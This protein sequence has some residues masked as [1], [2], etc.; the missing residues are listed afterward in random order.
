MTGKM[1]I[2]H[3]S[4]LHIGKQL[5]LYDISEVQRNVLAQIVELAKKERPDV[6]VIAGDIYDKAAPSGEAFRL[7]DEFLNGLG[8]IEPM[9]PVLIIAGNHDNHLRLH[10]ASSFLEKHQIYISSSLPKT[11]DEHLKK[12]VLEDE[13]GT[14]NFY[15]LPFTRPADGKNLFGK[16]VEIQ[17]YDDAVRMMIEREEI[18]VTQRNVLVAH[19]F[20]VKGQTEPEKRESELRY[21]SVGGID[22]VDTACVEHFDYV[23]LGHIHS[24]QSIGKPYIR[25]S[26]TPLKY[27]VSEEKDKKSIT[28]AVLGEKGEEPEFSFLPLEMKPDVRKIKG[29]LEELIAQAK[30]G[31][32]EDFVSIVLTD[33]KTPYK[34]K[35]R[36]Q[37][38]YDNILEISVENTRT[39]EILQQDV[40]ETISEDPVA[41]FSEF[42]Q[43]MNQTP[44]SDRERKVLEDI[45]KKLSGEGKGE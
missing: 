12:I 25:Y 23:A 42:Y 9:I 3:I 7:F 37:E 43:E 5:H 4:D 26:G 45:V 22:S 16:E 2:F 40:A 15:M 1:K 41:L 20:F 21:I 10:Y 29:T 30:E 11:S 32:N 6:I 35:E 38:C 34:A 17:T 33:E 44:I 39:R 28:V 31:D 13:Y 14:V 36:L 27:S 19:Q 24:S 8:S 18:D